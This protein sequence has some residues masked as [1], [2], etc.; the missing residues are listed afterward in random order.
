MHLMVDGPPDAGRTFIVAHGAGGPM[1]S[2]FM[3]LVAKG[4]SDRGIRV[5]RFEFPYMAARRRGKKSGAPDKPQVLEQCWKDVVAEV[6]NAPDLIIGGKSMG[7]RMASMVAD[8]LGVAGLVCLGYP[9]HPPGQPDKLRTEHLRDLK[10]PTLI[11]QGTHDMFGSRDEVATYR[12]SPSIRIEWLD[13]DH[14]FRPRALSGHTER[15]NLEQVV[16]SVADFVQTL[17]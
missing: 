6:G 4:L 2:K 3:N 11:V 16:R 1:D 15:E 5:V 12:L 10:T 14:S 13:G 7:G 9:F 17:S 8:K